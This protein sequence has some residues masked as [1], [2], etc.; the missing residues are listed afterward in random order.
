MSKKL[1]YIDASW[2]ALNQLLE[3]KEY[4]QIFVLVDSNT[5]EHC[6]PVLS[7]VL[8]QTFDIIEVEAGEAS[9]DLAICQYIWQDLTAKNADRNALIIN[10]GGGVVCDLGGFIASVYKRGIDFINIPTSLL[11]MVDASIGGK[12]GIDF[13]GFKNQLGAFNESISCFINPSFLKTLPAKEMKSGFAEML[14]H[15]LIA[16]RA[17]WETITKNGSISFTEIQ[18]SIAIKQEVVQS[19]P[20]EKGLRKVLNFG[21]T[22]GHAIET[23]MLFQGKEIPHG[24]AIAAGILAES[25]ISHQ[26][27]KLSLEELREII[28]VIQSNYTKV[29]FNQSDFAKVIEIIAQ[30]KKGEQG[31]NRF[32]LISE[33]GKAK[34][35]CR[36]ERDLIE[37]SLLFYLG[38]YES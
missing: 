15:G 9:K 34:I 21:H 37:D 20:L 28:E 1:E 14:K 16:D 19:D 31:E 23:Y 22:I 18:A 10:L 11:A 30:D 36:V 3:A 35:D 32:T 6:L 12:C 25:Y 29:D 4:S 7:P 8:I 24:Y 5:H 26:Q 27:S 33:I 38:V 17:H 13:M 2:L